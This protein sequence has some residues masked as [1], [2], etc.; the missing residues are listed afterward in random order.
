MLDTKEIRV[1][2]YQTS[3]ETLIWCLCDEVDKLHEELTKK[4]LQLH[5]AGGAMSQWQLCTRTAQQAVKIKKQEIEELHKRLIAAES[6]TRQWRAIAHA[7]LRMS[8]L[9]N[10]QIENLNW[11]I[12][13]CQ[14]VIASDA[15]EIAGLHEDLRRINKEAREEIG[16]RKKQ[17]KG[18]QAYITSLESTVNQLE[19]EVTQLRADNKE[20]LGKLRS[21]NQDIMWGERIG[22][23]ISS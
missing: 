18:L 7:N 11:K 14:I 2:A 1:R 22:R 12:E 3:M 21:K 8:E 16:E 17:I 13:C 20:L 15:K 4:D 23:I 10:E 19:A 5:T 6:A 9:R